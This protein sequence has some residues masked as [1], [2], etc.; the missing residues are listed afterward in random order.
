[1]QAFYYQN[2]GLGIVI[3]II[4]IIGSFNNPLFAFMVRD[5]TDRQKRFLHFIVITNALALTALLVYANDLQFF[6]LTIG[7]YVVPGGLL[8]RYIK[9]GN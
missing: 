3:A 5:C 8:Y 4:L 2:W 7:I 9:K 6:L 1:M